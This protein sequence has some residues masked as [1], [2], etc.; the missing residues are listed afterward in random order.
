M[1]APHDIDRTRMVIL[2][3]QDHSEKLAR[4]LKNMAKAGLES[5]LLCD[6]ANKF[7]LTGRIFDGF[8]YISPGGQVSYFVRRPSILE[9]PDVHHIRKPENILEII[10]R[11]GLGRPSRL[12]L[13][14]T[15]ASYATVMRLAAA[16]NA[17]TFGNADPVMLAARAVKTD[18]ELQMIAECGVCHD[19]VYS[20][21]PH[22]Y[23]DGMSDVELQI[24][25]ERLTRLEGGLGIIRTVGQDMEINMGSVLA[26]RNADEPSPYDFA[27]GGAGTS[28][29]LPVGADGTVLRAGMSVMVDT[30][31]D[32]N[33]YMTDMTR[34][35]AIGDLPR[36]AVDLHKLSCDICH[37]IEDMARP[38]V[39]CAD[40]CRTALDMAAKAG[41]SDL[42]MGHN[43]QAAFIGHGIGIA[44]NELPVITLKT[45]SVLEAGNVLA[46]EPKFV[47]PD[48][49]AVGIENTYA[50]TADGPLRR[51]TNAPEDLI[52]L[53]S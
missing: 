36:R 28:P 30:N 31:G 43:S 34:S 45:D 15:Q 21:I 44:L 25:I 11:E 42:F 6:N 3:E 41:A 17:D 4:V 53:V 8:I 38:G 40:L 52:T 13:E 26:G 19:R 27:L 32:F 48:V 39:R 29:A 16:L 12:G 2:P 35:F 51:M 9:G 37:T 22:L 1:K 20:R 24:E 7:Y 23:H 47:I 33:G 18:Y 10:D 14:L 49:G 50:V 46:I 5:V